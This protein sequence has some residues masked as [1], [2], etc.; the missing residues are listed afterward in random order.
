MKRVSFF[1]LVLGLVSATGCIKSTSEA[2][3]KP[4]GSVSVKLSIAY[5]VSNFDKIRSVPDDCTCWRV[6]QVHP[7]S[8]PVAR[9]AIAA[10]AAA[11]DARKLTDNWSK[12][13]LTV[14]KANVSE[15]DNWK[16][17]DVEASAA[18]VADFHTKLAAALKA[19]GPDEYITAIPWYLHTRKFLPRLPRFYKT[20]DPTV[21]KAVI[22]ISDVGADVGSLATLTPDARHNLE[23]Q[24]TYMK[25]LRAFNQ[26]SMTVR[27]KLPGT[28]VSAENAKTEGADVVVFTLDGRSVEPETISSLA[29]AKGEIIAMVKIEPA[30]FKI[31]LDG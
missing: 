19:A 29:K 23:R 28:I 24:I 30:T 1:A 12:L 9:R 2:A 15:S 18:S 8:V 3:V 20:A 31:A 6:Y 5:Q 11:F 27:V 25:A 16:T 22:P 26:G 13:G 4:D 10:F 14:T 7:D 17:I 21:V